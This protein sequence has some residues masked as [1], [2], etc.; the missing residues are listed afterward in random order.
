MEW[1]ML[2]TNAK[3]KNT[4]SYHFS[5]TP[6]DFFKTRWAYARVI[7]IMHH[8][9]PTVHT[10]HK[11]DMHIHDMFP[12]QTEQSMTQHETLPKKTYHSI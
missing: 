8:V 11:N 6:H 12:Q 9:P 4:I 2:A 3:K 5:C 10:K 1:R 7:Y